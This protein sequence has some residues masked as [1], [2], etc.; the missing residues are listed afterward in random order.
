MKIIAEPVYL[1]IILNTYPGAI[2]EIARFI[3]QKIEYFSKFNSQQE[4]EKYGWENG[5]K[6]EF[7]QKIGDFIV[8]SQEDYISPELLDKKIFNK[9]LSEVYYNIIQCLK[10]YLKLKDDYYN[11]IALWIIGTYFHKNFYS[12]PYL[13]FN[14]MKGS[15]KSRALNLITTLSRDGESLNSLTDA[16]LFRTDGTLAIDEFEGLGRK[17]KES[18]IELLNSAYKKGTKVKRMKQQK[19]MEGVQQVVEEFD[20]Y[21]PI[22]I[23]N[24]F[25]MESVLGDRCIQ[26][27]LEKSFD[28]KI[29]N[30]IEIF[31]VD[32]L[33]QNTI[34]MLKECSL[35]RCSFSV[36]C[37]KEW[38]NYVINN[39]TNN[40]N[41]NNNT[42]NTNN[43]FPF[44]VFKELNSVDL[45]GR[46]LELSLPII[47]IAGEVSI[48][49][50]K[51]TTL[52]L[53]NIFNDKQG[54]DL[55]ENSD[56]SLIDFVS[57]IPNINDTIF[58][59]IL[60]LTNDFKSFIQINEDWLN[61]KWMGRAL[62]RLDLI[63]ERR[64]KSYGVEVRLNLK[65]ARERINM[66]K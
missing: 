34:K 5:E 28:K 50:L 26:L 16:V 22:L 36:E 45:N 66:F 63:I 54:E 19:T 15:G 3:K 13:F 65:K 64:R 10:K 62:K 55:I 57:Q 4:L 44:K 30:L 43:I 32:D 14:A 23:A 9:K 7:C 47:L 42:N 51:E 20:V 12:Y 31:E 58:H 21:R 41:N 52:T 17:G 18:L 38:N 1:K 40:T 33:I 56:I 53:K 25:G 6:K 49:I 27:I 59:S 8:F 24:I 48:E 46:E 37:Y 61:S 35:C 29:V 39:N 11:I 60:N 2:N